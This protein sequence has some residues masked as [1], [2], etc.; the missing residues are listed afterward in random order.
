MPLKDPEA[1]RAYH[2]EYM[3]KRLKNDE[4]YR[5]KHLALV[6]KNDVRAREAIGALIASFRAKGCA[7][8]PEKEPCCLS[9]HHLDK[10]AKDF[11]V[12]NAKG[13][14]LGVPRTVAELAKCVCLCENCHRKVHAGVLHLP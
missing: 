3:Q 2:R 11:S 1:R 5:Q 6:R 13:R 12:A 7:L 14:K 9:A 4:A 10:D 8:C